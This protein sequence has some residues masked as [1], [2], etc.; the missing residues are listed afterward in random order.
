MGW[1]LPHPLGQSIQIAVRG[2]SNSNS[3]KNFVVLL[4]ICG[5]SDTKMG[6]FGVVGGFN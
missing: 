3:I 5:I 2:I 1:I 4:Y 6:E